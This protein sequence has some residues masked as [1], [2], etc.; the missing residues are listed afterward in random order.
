MSLLRICTSRMQSSAQF[1][2]FVLR[3]RPDCL[4]ASIKQCALN[5]KSKLKIFS[6]D[7]FQKQAALCVCL[8]H[9][10]CSLVAFYQAV[11]PGRARGSSACSAVGAHEHH[12]TL[13]LQFVPAELKSAVVCFKCRPPTSTYI[14]YPFSCIN[15]R[16]DSETVLGIFINQIHLGGKMHHFLGF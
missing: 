15:I 16:N 13:P 6:L 9:P 8:Q 11:L 5:F 14:P 12:T 7:A 2:A 10:F 3:M 1:G 4:L